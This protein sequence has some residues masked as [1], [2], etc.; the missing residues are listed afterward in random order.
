[1]GL[2]EDFIEYWE[3]KPAMNPVNTIV[4]KQE[5]AKLR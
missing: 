2:V 5:E 3:M 4:R 1:M